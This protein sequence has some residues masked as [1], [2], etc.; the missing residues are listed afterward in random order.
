MFVDVRDKRWIFEFFPVKN[1]CQF[2][3]AMI[4]ACKKF[5]L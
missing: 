2:P 5:K 3:H 1:L 4:L